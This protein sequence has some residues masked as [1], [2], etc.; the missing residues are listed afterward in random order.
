VSL[1][2]SDSRFL[3]PNVVERA[4][5]LGDRHDSAQALIK[6]GIELDGRSPDLVLAPAALV[7]QAV[8]TRAATVILE[9]PDAARTLHA[10]GLFA[11]TYLPLPNLESP[12][13]FVPV[14]SPVA[15][16]ALRVWMVAWARW[17]V[18]RNAVAGEMLAQG[19]FPTVRPLVTVG[20]RGSVRPFLVAAAADLG[21]ARD[22]DW[23]LAPGHGDV[24][25]RGAFVLFKPGAD[26]P[27]WVLKFSRIR[28]PDDR[29]DSDARGL[30]LAWGSG[31]AVGRHAPRFLGQL[32]SGGFHAS[33]E[34]A[35][36]GRRLNGVMSSITPRT[37]KLHT[38]DL[39]VDWLAQVAR[40]T[41]RPPQLLEQE[42]DRLRRDVV[43]RWTAF[44]A[45]TDLV[46]RVPPIPGVL[47]H[48]DPGTWNIVARDAEFTVLDWESARPCGFPIWDTLYFLADALANLDGARLPVDRRE[49]FRRLFLGELPSS[50]V[51]LEFMRR[52][53]QASD[54]PLE[55]VGPLATLCWLHHA[56]SHHTRRGKAERHE[57]ASGDPGWMFHEM[58]TMWLSTPG[59]G[60]DWKPRIS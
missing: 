5:V 54:V 46:E 27:S 31:E 53:T 26:T 32:E 52:V 29:I 21:V 40:E 36:P 56:L 15:R 37:T 11:R 39:V 30:S 55:A 3:A 49:H 59:L 41:A 50:R 14:A 58:A 7:E 9:G 43:P 28:G 48:N 57:R 8:A 24:L 16:Y 51:L 13:I 22:A 19:L 35:A 42:R 1:Q 47:Q 38:I 10:H 23:F 18:V 45:P 12:Q 25:A 20:A 44:G 2:R 4:V 17:K 34:T 33:L 6:A 60:P